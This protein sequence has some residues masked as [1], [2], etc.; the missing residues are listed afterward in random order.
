M[1]GSWAG[2]PTPR[3]EVNERVG[4]GAVSP[5]GHASGSGGRGGER[6]VPASCPAFG[7]AEPSV[8]L[9]CHES[10]QIQG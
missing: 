3:A 4:P 8:L 2:G 6:H 1:A 5:Y 9:R 10:P 7:V